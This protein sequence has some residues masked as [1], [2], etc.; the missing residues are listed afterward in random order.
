MRARRGYRRVRQRDGNE[1]DRAWRAGPGHIMS[2]RT[3]PLSTSAPPVPSD[4][5]RGVS[6]SK[7]CQNFSQVLRTGAGGSDQTYDLS[8]PCES[9]DVFLSHSWRDS[10][11][12]KYLAICLHFNSGM[13]MAAGLAASALL[14]YLQRYCGV[15]GLPFV[16]IVPF[17]NVVEDLQAGV[18][19][20]GFE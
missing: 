19:S 1:H 20:A 2:R 11:F 12:L 8:Q 17:M 7:V 6:S 16:P 10:G 3:V 13:A 15:Q 4:I 5:L 14:F 18:E 9:L